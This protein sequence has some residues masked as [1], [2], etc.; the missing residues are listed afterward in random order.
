M[1]NFDQSKQSVNSQFNA[2]RDIVNNKFGITNHNVINNHIPP[3]LE[4]IKAAWTAALQWFRSMLPATRQDLSSIVQFDARH[5]KAMERIA[6]ERLELEKMDFSRRAYVENRLIQLEEEEKRL[7]KEKF[8]WEKLVAQEN[9]RLIQDSHAI[10]LKAQQ[11]ATDQHFLPLEVSRDDTIQI[12]SQ[13]NG[14]FVI[15][16]SP[17]E[18]LRDDLQAFKSLKA[19]IPPRLKRII[20]K[21]YGEVN[22]S[23]IGY[24]SIFNKS[25]GEGNAS[26]VGRFIAP[27]PTLIF[28]S[29]VTH[30]KIFIWVTL[31]C[32][33]MK[34]IASQTQTTE[35]QFHMEINQKSFLL[36]EWNWMDLKKEFEAQGQDY[37]T[38]SQAILDLISS[39]HL[40]VALYFCDLYCLNLNP[41]HS[42][43][44]FAFLAEP[45]FPLGLQV[46]SQPL[47]NSLIETQKKIKEE[48]E[49][50][51]VSETANLK[52]NY[53]YTDFN[54]FLNPPVIASVIGLIFLFAMCSQQSHQMTGG[55]SSI[56]RSIE[57]P[58]TR[59][60]I[61][62]VNRPGEN[63]ARLRTAPD[64]THSKVVTLLRNGTPVVVE[65]ISNDGQWQ[66]VTTREGVSG[67]VWAEFVALR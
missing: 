49:R 29:Q 55:N 2:A 54:D 36:P 37:D 40:V 6:Q 43:K 30:Q 48:L 39:I 67:W 58:Q 28:H 19:E 22:E 46:W 8:E 52:R 64:L 42:P 59:T 25:I 15:I 16:P 9:L 26:V 1:S 41:S 14:K 53:N 32:P 13:D 60:G 61:I 5:N 27:I 35:P 57:Q 34:E 51:Y 38:S 12:L 50:L 56:Q 17:P 44:L 7:Q 66:R 18:V 23:V 4:T 10:A 45:D 3:P 24:R 20:E 21:Y 33:V 11:N 31:T 47:Q 65:E 63:A 62:W